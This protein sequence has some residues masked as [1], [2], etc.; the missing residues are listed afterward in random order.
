MLP[1]LLY[2]IYSIT[3]AEHWHFTQTGHCHVTQ[4]EHCHVTQ[5]EHCHA[6]Q[7]EHCH[8]TQA[9][10]CHATPAVHCHVTTR[11]SD[12]ILNPN[13]D[14]IFKFYWAVH[15]LTGRYCNMYSYN[16]RIKCTFNQHKEAPVYFIVRSVGFQEL[17]FVYRIFLNFLRAS[18]TAKACLVRSFK[19]SLFS[20]IQI[21]HSAL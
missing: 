15:L 16:T 2:Y 6:T 17:H 10:H 20:F 1:K 14:M 8:V 9:E 3:Q 12:L 21:G 13:W 4:A 5:A 7:A 18:Q 11:T 19:I